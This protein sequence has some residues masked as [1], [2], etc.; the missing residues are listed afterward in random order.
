MAE[1]QELKRGQQLLGS[2]MTQ[3]EVKVDQRLEETEGCFQNEFEL[4]N[5]RLKIFDSAID[6][7]LHSLESGQLRLE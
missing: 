2:K 3:F 5:K 7:G 6:R 1:I 4:H